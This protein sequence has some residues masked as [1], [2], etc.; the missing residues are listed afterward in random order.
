[1]EI[2]SGYDSLHLVVDRGSRDKILD[3]VE[4]VPPQNI[5]IAGQIRSVDLDRGTAIIVDAISGGRYELKENDNLRFD[6]KLLG[7]RV[8]IKG[9]IL[10]VVK[11]HGGV[12]TKVEVA[13]IVPFEINTI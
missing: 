9:K 13:S 11:R 8:Y 6:R 7:S 1:M 3:F 2:Q 4:S 12:R 5:S 10:S